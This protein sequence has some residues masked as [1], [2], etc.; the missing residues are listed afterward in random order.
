MFLHNQLLSEAKA[1][2]GALRQLAESIDK[3]TPLIYD[4]EHVVKH[5]QSIEEFFEE[6]GDDLSEVLIYMAAL[7]EHFEEGQDDSTRALETQLSK[8]VDLLKKLSPETEIPA[9]SSF[10]PDMQNLGSPIKLPESDRPEDVVN[11]DEFD[12]ISPEKAAI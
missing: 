9:P 8:V 12:A 3:D 10:S 5:I 1:E 4:G 6:L 2:V 11:D 7:H